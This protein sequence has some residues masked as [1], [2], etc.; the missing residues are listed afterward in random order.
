MA[1]HIKLR[2]HANPA[3]TGIHNDVA[4][5]ILSVELSVRASSLQLR[6]HLALDPE[7]LIFRDMPVQHIQ[8]HSLH[9]IDVLPDNGRRHKMP[10]GIDHQTAPWEPRSVIDHHRS[11]RKTL[12]SVLH[13]LKK[14]LQ[15]MEHPERIRRAQ[16]HLLGRY[17]KPVRLIL[18]HLLQWQTLCLRV[19]LELR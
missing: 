5:L 9:A 17:F 11:N 18:A 14:C 6:K 16:R 10:S 7:S 4:N 19:D 8:L 12:R 1:W 13:Q 3:I 2:I 15:S